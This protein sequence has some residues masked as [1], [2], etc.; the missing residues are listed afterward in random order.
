RTHRVEL[1][2]TGEVTEVP[3]LVGV[4]RGALVLVNDDDLTYCK[5]VLDPESLRTAIAR[6]GD[7]AESLP[8]TLVW[9]AVWEM[10]RDAAMRARDFVAMALTGIDAE[11]EIGVVQRVLAQVQQA[12]G[13]YAEPGWAADVGWPTV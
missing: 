8:R 5:L 12:V 4:S 1:D 3:G 13:Y 10:T 6:I 9:S 11:S 2:V 7:I